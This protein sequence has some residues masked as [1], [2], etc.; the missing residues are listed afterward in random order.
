MRRLRP[1]CPLGDRKPD[2][3]KSSGVPKA[4]PASR[5]A[6]RARSL[7]GA[8]SRWRAPGSRFPWPGHARR[9]PPSL[10]LR[11]HPRPRSDGARQV[12][13]VHGLLG[14]QAAAGRTRAALEA[15]PAF[16]AGA[17]GGP[18]APPRPRARAGR[19]GP[20]APDR[21]DA[22]GASPRPPRIRGPDRLPIDPVLGGPA[23]EHLLRARKQVPELITVV[24]PTARPTG[25]GIAGRPSA[26]VRPPSR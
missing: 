23:G 12:G 13:H 1:S 18:R 19:F 9:H 26:I 25:V 4:P 24:P 22:R 20:S 7:K 11:P 8:L 2:R 16:A 17:R 10:D 15:G 14:V 3:S 6:R 21:R 5:T